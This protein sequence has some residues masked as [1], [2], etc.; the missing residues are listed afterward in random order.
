[1]LGSISTPAV[2]VAT[3]PTV[4]STFFSHVLARRK[5]KSSSKESLATGGP[6]GGP[7]NELSYEEGLKVVRRF[8]DYASH[9]G[10]EE[11]QAFT[12]MKVPNSREC[13]HLQVISER[14]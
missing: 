13:V 5:R 9:H 11:V 3:T 1:M 4:V 12:G 7:E 6:G 10:V 2:A 8:L 14:A